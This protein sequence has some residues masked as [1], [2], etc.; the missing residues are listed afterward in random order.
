MDLGTGT[1][2]LSRQNIL[3]V[4]GGQGKQSAVLEMNIWI[5]WSESNSWIY[6]YTSIVLKKKLKK[7]TGLVPEDRC[8][9]RGL[10]MDTDHKFKI[11]EQK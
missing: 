5:Y 3:D 10:G 4:N 1:L 2:F 11:T 8:L 7:I 9:T 6:F